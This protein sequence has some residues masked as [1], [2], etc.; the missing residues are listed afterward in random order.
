VREKRG[1]NDVAD[2]AFRRHYGQVYR[3]VRRRTRDHHRAE[4]LTQQVFADAAAALEDDHPAPALAW[5]YTVARRRFAD[6]VRRATQARLVPLDEVADA[7]E[8]G[9]AVASE[10]SAA[11]A[12]LPP[13]QRDV[14][15]LKLLR[16]LRFA[17]IA[18]T[19]GLTE[20]AAKM[21]F[22][23]ALQALRAELELRGVTP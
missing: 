12:S 15:V 14:V 22:V 7:R 19:L 6:E 23:R 10:L 20:D 21:R 4:E 16:G 18:E 13:G 8:Y 2:R 11:M 1:V 3:Y 17:E 5:L 9:P